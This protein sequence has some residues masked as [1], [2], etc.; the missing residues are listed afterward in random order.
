MSRVEGLLGFKCEQSGGSPRL[1]SVSRVEGLLGFKC[2][3]S[4]GS[5]RL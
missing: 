5:P 4:G 1:L 3:Q 2:E